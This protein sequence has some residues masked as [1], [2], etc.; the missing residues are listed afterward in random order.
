VVGT[1]I[2]T[3]DDCM[4]VKRVG[5][6]PK[7]YVSSYA[8]YTSLLYSLYLLRRI[9]IIIIIMPVRHICHSPIHWHL[10]T[11]FVL[12]FIFLCSSRPCCNNI[13]IKPWWWIG[14]YI[15]SNILY[16]PTARC[17]PTEQSCSKYTLQIQFQ[18]DCYRAVY[19]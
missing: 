3:L 16:T 1:R 13:V 19:R 7:L 4:R 10:K 9:I 8:M 5:R 18:T 17:V 6:L 12:L 15:Y 2:H 14:L 11:V